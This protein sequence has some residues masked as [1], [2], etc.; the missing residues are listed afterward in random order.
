MKKSTVPALRKRF[1]EIDAGILQ[2]LDARAGLSEEMARLKK[3]MKISALQKDVW[4][5]HLQKRL[6]EN[7]KLNNSP[8]FVEFLFKII[9]KESLRIQK[10]AMKNKK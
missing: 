7:K 4:E 8:V 3:E 1:N 5:K 6:R 2:L 9:H 10:Q